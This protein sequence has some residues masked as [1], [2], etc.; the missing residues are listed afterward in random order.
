MYWTRFA[1]ACLAVYGFYHLWG[2]LFHGLF[3]TLPVVYESWVFYPLPLD[4]AHAWFVSGVVFSVIAG[5]IVAAIYSPKPVA[6]L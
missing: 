6:G 5:V 1:L 4:L 2:W 3:M